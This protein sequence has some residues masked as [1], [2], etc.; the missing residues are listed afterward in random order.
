MTRSVALNRLPK[1]V[2]FPAQLEERISYDARQQQLR[3]DGAMSKSEF[4]QLVQLHN[5]IAYQR[6]LQELFQKCTFPEKPTPSQ[7]VSIGLV[8]RVTQWLRG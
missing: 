5:D 7:R 3:F 1:E 4:D 6:A 2:Q 8:Q